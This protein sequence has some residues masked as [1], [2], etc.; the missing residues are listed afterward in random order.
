M[1]K[2]TKKAFEELRKTAPELIAKAVAQS[3]AA[4]A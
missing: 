1:L 4:P 2:L 3:E